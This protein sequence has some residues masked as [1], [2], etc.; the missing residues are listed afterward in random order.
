MDNYAQNKSADYFRQPAQSLTLKTSLP[1]VT[2]VTIT[3]E[4]WKMKPGRLIEMA[5]LCILFSEIAQSLCYLKIRKIPGTCTE[6][7]ALSR[8]ERCARERRPSVNI[9]AK[10]VHLSRTYSLPLAKFHS[11]LQALIKANFHR[12]SFNRVERTTDVALS[13]HYV[14]IRGDQLLTAQTSR[15][16]AFVFK[17]KQY[18]SCSSLQMLPMALRSLS[19]IHSCMHL[20]HS[21]LVMIY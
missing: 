13:R 11:R 10:Q 15:E 20:K 2:Q 1:G 16:R 12:V 3:I 4:T 19:V 5:S 7:Y 9:Y 14:H 21:V 6:A 8:F 17:E 18:F